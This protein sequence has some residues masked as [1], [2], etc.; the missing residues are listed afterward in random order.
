MRARRCIGTG[1]LGPGIL[2]TTGCYALVAV[3]VQIGVVWGGLGL[4]L[5][6]CCITHRNPPVSP[7]APDTG[8]PAI[9]VGHKRWAVVDRCRWLRRGCGRRLLLLIRGHLR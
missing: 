2:P 7:R 1:A 3:A 4:W 9:R 8:G 6:W 5:S